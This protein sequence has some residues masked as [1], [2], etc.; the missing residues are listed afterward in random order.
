MFANKYLLKNNRVPLIDTAPRN[1]CNIRIVIPC[2]NE[3]LLLHTLNSLKECELPETE[4]EVI[5]LINHSEVA[6]EEIKQANLRTKTDAENWIKLNRVRGI[7]FFVLGPIEL[8]RKWAGVGLARKTGLDEAVLRFNFF[9]MRDGIIVSL[10]ADSLVGSN[11]LVEIERYFK[12]NPKQVGATIKVEHQKVG[13]SEKQKRGIELYER[14]LVYYKEV[15]EFTGYPQAMITIGSAFAVTAEAYVKRGGMNRRQAGEDFYFLQNLAQLG[16]V[17]EITTTRV[18]PSARLSDRVPFGTGA[19]IQKW[20]NGADDLNLVYNFSAFSDL[21]VFFDAKERLFQTG[22]TEYEKL[23]SALALPVRQFLLKD[24]FWTDIQD[25]NQNCSTLKSFQTRFYQK[26]NAFKVMKFMNF[27][28]E[29]YYEKASLDV[30]CGL[31]DKQK[32]K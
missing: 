21:K 9:N 2:Y 28:H 24:N 16:T 5:V 3:T 7:S 11:Y 4:T 26:F 14:Y 23:I 22:I 17:G 1:N 20:M 30:Q 6:S 10:D 15:L 31:L 29:D 19:A 27:A 32:T 18:Y 13:L 25:L 12:L 8:P